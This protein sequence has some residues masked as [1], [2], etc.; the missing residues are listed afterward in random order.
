[1]PHEGEVYAIFSLSGS[2]Y[3]GDDGV[4]RVASDGCDQRL[5]AY[6]GSAAAASVD[7]G[8]ND[9]TP[10]AQTWAQGD[11]R[12]VCTLSRDD[13]RLLVGSQRSGGESSA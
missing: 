9:Y 1:M 3:P 12:V 5:P 4:D 7:W 6:V 11:R 8:Y 13:G 10:T 2:K